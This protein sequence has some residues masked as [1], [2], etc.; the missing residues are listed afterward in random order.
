MGD[1][2]DG[3]HQG[4]GFTGRPGESAGLQVTHPETFVESNTS[5]NLQELMISKS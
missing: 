4:E 1:S 2:I 3:N 5:P